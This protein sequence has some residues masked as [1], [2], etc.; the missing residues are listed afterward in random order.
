[1]KSLLAK[2]VMGREIGVMIDD[3][4]IAVSRVATTVL[5]PVELTRETAP[6]RT[7]QLEATLARLVKPLLP[8]RKLTRVKVVVGL[9]ILRV[10]Y[11]T[12]PIQGNNRDASPEVLL[13][14]VLQSPTIN[15]DELHVDL[16]KTQPG[17][18]PLASLVSCRK[19]YLSNILAAFEAIEVMPMRAEP[20]PCACSG[21]RGGI[22]R[23]GGP[24]RSCASS[25]ARA[26]PWPC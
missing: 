12:R 11:S 14:E 15:I 18:R 26:A 3:H 23:P 2:I 9:P 17:R 16:I 21:T 24:R 10:F 13:H 7:E 4:E 5:G 22:A 25:W 20:A 8:R 19:K 6:L 1:M